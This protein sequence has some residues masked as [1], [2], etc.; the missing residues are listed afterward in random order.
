MQFFLYCSVCGIQAGKI[1]RPKRKSVE[2]FA[3][4]YWKHAAPIMDGM[5]MHM[6]YVV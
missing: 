3:K 2:D 1:V 4:F 5:M 6:E